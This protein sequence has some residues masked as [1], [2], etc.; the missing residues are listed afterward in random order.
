MLVFDHELLIIFRFFPCPGTL[1][2]D[3]STSE[4]EGNYARLN[5][6]KLLNP[7]LKTLLSLG[8]AK[9]GDTNH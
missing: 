5:A 3:E 4:Y 2:D 8:G 9:A 1:W 7:K 6:L